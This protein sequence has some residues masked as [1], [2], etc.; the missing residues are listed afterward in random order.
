MRVS[1]SN[2]NSND[3]G[4]HRSAIESDTTDL[5]PSPLRSST[6]DISSPAITAWLRFS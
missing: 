2:E 3:N 1:D 6:A 5:G 4:E